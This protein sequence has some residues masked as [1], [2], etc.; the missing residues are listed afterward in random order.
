MRRGDS[1]ASARTESNCGLPVNH[2]LTFGHL[3]QEYLQREC[4]EHQ[5][6]KRDS[7]G[8]GAKFGSVI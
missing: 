4:D 1:S 7:F 5:E 6:D 2:I 3:L 8:K